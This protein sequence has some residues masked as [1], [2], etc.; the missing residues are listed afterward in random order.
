MQD[1]KAWGL[2]IWILILALIMGLIGGVA[3][4]L[5]FPRVREIA[6]LAPTGKM[7]RPMTVLPSGGTAGSNIFADV[8]AQVIPT[9]VNISVVS[10]V[11]QAVQQKLQSQEVPD[12]PDWLQKQFPFLPAPIPKEQRGVGSGVIIQPDGIILTNEHVI[13]DAKQIKITLSDGRKFP[14]K[15]IGRDRE[16]DLAVVKIKADNLPAARLGDS[17]QLRPG[18]WALTVGSPLGLSSSVTL[19]VIS[20]LG[21]P[22]NVED[23][24]YNNLI[25]TDASIIPGNSGGPLINAAGEV[26]GINTAI[27]LTMDERSLGAIAARIGFAV[28]IDLVKEVLPDLISKGK[29]IRPWVGITMREIQEEDVKRWQLPQ[30]EGIIIETVLP[31]GP[32][33]RAGLF[34]GDIIQE[35]DGQKPKDSPGVQAL[36]RRHKPGETVTFKVL[37]EAANGSWRERTI[38]VKTEVMPENVS[39]PKTPEP[40]K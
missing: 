3:G 4:S 6:A 24:S 16:L 20:A 10:E 11:P 13:K 1:K 21:R 27:Q 17:S 36:V 2:T 5:L 19:G 28:P 31:K 38:K 25:Q 34:K 15:V 26:V 29:V 37:R 12:L 40:E 32:A 22:I 8:A 30:K 9:V 39:L 33:Q 35:I 23:R 14:G 7:S 18:D